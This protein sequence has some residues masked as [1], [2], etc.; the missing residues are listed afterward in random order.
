MVEPMLKEKCSTQEILPVFLEEVIEDEIKLKEKSSRK[1]IL[2][3]FLGVVIVTIAV[4]FT[5]TVLQ[6][7]LVNNQFIYDFGELMVGSMDG[8]LFYR[9]MWFFADLTEAS[10]LASAPASI[11]M[12]IMAFAAAALEKKKSKHAGTGVDGN[13]EIFSSMFFSACASMILGQLVFGNFFSAGWIASFLTVQAFVAYYGGGFVKSATATVAGTIVT[14]LAC[15]YLLQYVIMPLK[16]PLFIAVSIGIFIAVPLCTQIFHL[17]PWMTPKIPTPPAANS[18][19]PAPTPTPAKFFLHRVFGDIGELNFWG[20]SLATIGMYIGAIISWVLN[21]MH[22]CYGSGNFPLVMC[23]QILTAALAI[24]IYYPKWKQG[25]WAFTFASVVFTSAI[26][27][28]YPVHPVIVIPTIIIAAVVFAPL[29]EW[30][31]KILKFKGQFH[32]IPYI[33]LAI[34]A[35]CS[36]WSFVV[37]YLIMPALVL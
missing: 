37:M 26:V 1:E 6:P 20:S 17:M 25:G 16:L 7:Y 21:P 3:V 10:F 9:I 27:S 11:I 30:I 32:P 22:P 31:L 2:P 29:V 14:F 19:I 24:F 5:M 18:D 15:H 34:F 33:Q 4:Y 23:A 35:V 13:N 28:T 8:N 12:C 36:A